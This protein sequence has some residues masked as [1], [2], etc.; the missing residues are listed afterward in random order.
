VKYRSQYK[1]EVIS[2]RVLL[3]KSMNLQYSSESLLIVM[4]PFAKLILVS[5]GGY[6][7]LE[8]SRE[9]NL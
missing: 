3:V 9:I 4:L 5:K 6:I 8:I 2:F 1:T 7:I